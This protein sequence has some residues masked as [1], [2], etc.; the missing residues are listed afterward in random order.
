MPTSGGVRKCAV[1]KGWAP[2]STLAPIPTLATRLRSPIAAPPHRLTLPSGT[3]RRSSNPR[4]FR[5]FYRQRN[6]TART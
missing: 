4:G 1:R 2:P 3:P 6:I 5:H